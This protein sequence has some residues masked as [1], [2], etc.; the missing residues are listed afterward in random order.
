MQF[1]QA[2]CSLTHWND[3][4]AGSHPE[5]IIAD[6]DLD[7]GQGMRSLALRLREVGVQKLTFKLYGSGSM[8]NYEL[9]SPGYMIAGNWFPEYTL[10][11]D[12]DQPEPGWNAV[13]VEAW[14]LSGQPKWAERL[15]PTERI[16]RSI[17]LYYFPPGK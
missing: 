6:T 11:P 16:G 1:F 17:F 5:R 9:Y 14:K 3:E 7:W 10:M 13:S 15:Q 8:N 12:G 2:S 4:L